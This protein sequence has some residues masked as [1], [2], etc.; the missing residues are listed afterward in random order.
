MAVIDAQNYERIIEVSIPVIEEWIALKD[1]ENL[2]TLVKDWRGNRNILETLKAQL[3]NCNKKDEAVRLSDAITKGDKITE[4]AQ[5][6]IGINPLWFLAGG[7]ALLST[8]A[9]FFIKKRRGGFS[10]YEDCGCG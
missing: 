5:A 8:A 2:R 4:R 9:V 10:E 3:I 1:V 7:A 6:A